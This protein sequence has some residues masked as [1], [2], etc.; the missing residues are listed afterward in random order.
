M[1]A[2]IVFEKR[3]RRSAGGRHR[4]QILAAV[5]VTRTGCE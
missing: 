2:H 1:A 5:G 3:C 4:Y